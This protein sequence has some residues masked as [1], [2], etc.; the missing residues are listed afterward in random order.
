MQQCREAVE[1]QSKIDSSNIIEGKRKRGSGAPSS[2]IGNITADFIAGKELTT[3]KRQKKDK[4]EKKV[5]F[6]YTANCIPI[7]EGDDP[8]KL[9]EPMIS[10]M[11]DDSSFFRFWK[12]IDRLEGGKIRIREVDH[13]RKGGCVTP[14]TTS[15]T[16]VPLWNSETD[17]ERVIDSRQ[18]GMQT[19]LKIETDTDR[20]YIKWCP[21]IHYKHVRK[22]V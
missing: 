21:D 20:F 1:G 11:W 6:P 2:T 10:T 15:F 18:V 4:K 17:I 5:R 16:L 3:S 8:S 22:Y 13:S 9:V 12:V 14:G 19:P 7:P